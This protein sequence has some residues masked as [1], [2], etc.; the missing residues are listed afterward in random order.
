MPDTSRAL[1]SP[2]FPLALALAALAG[3]VDAT[4]FVRLARIY[5][6]FMGGN[7]TK[8]ATALSAPHP[9][10]LPLLGC[11]LVG[12]VAGVVAGE[13]LAGA[14]GRR[15]HA[16]VLLAESIFLFAAMG[17]AFPPGNLLAPA[18]LLAFA[19]GMQNA[20]VHE[21]GGVS[22]AVTYVTGTLVHFGRQIAAT[23]AG[24]ASWRAP[25]IYLFLWLAMMAG[26]GG[27]AALA[28]VNAVSA[29]G[30][31]AVAALGLA[32]VVLFVSGQSEKV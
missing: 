16:A 23:L 2:G 28:R 3:W 27:G 18:L 31:A 10:K 32:G 12:F 14:A 1:R 6:S 17:A 11:A 22:I 25:L 4:A 13:S 8:L 24:R 7:S 21:V 20:S 26:A 5:V 15:G 29:I 9:S 30:M 19:L